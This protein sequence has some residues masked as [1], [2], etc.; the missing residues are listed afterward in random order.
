MTWPPPTLTVS[1]S[2]TLLW[3]DR[4]TCLLDTLTK[5]SGEDFDGDA[6]SVISL[7]VFALG[8]LAIEST[9]GHPVEIYK[10]LL[11]GIKSGTAMIPLGLA[12]FNEV[13]KR[14]GFLIA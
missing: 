11:S 7:L 13:R 5:I 3:T 10:G 6:G 12:Y 4:Q 1:T 9:Q 14:I 8:E 2:F